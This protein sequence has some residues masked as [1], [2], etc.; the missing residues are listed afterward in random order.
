MDPS[1]VDDVLQDAFIKLL[2][3]NKHFSNK[4]EAYNYMRKVV[5]VTPLVYGPKKGSKGAVSLHLP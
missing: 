5:L 4:N 3:S 1:S 2:K